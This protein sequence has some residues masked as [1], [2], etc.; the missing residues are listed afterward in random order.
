MQ[1]VLTH[2]T[3]LIAWNE[4]TTVCRMFS[5]KSARVLFTDSLGRFSGGR[6]A[7][8][9]RWGNPRQTVSGG[10]RRG[11][12]PVPIPNTE[13]KPSTA[14]GTAR[15]TV[16]ESRSLPGL[17]LQARCESVGPFFVYAA[18]RRRAVYGNTT[19]ARRK[20]RAASVSSRYVTL[21]ALH[22]ASPVIVVAATT[23]VS[24]APAPM[25]FGPPESP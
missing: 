2:A 21:V 9:R 22:S 13:V 17:F 3:A 12:T 19:N 7:C 16:W 8:R 18:A 20:E 24:S 15:V 25:K 10:H 1:R 23:F 4:K 11:V 6:L 14:D 5:R